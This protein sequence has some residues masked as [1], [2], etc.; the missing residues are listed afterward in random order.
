MNR[1]LIIVVPAVEKGRGGGHLCR[2]V[3]LAS[4][5]RSAGREAFLFLPDQSEKAHA[6]EID[7]LVESM[8]FNP[9]WCITNE[10]IIGSRE[11]IEFV[12]LDRFQTPKEELS[13]WKK[14]APVIG[15]DEGGSS[16]GGFDFLIDILV[17]EKLGFPPA[18]IASPALLNFPPKAPAKKQPPDGKL[19]ILVTFGHEDSAG[20]GLAVTR[21]L[22]DQNGADKMDVT[23]LCGALSKCE[24]ENLP[25]AKIIEAIPSLAEHLGEYDL[26]ITHYGITSYEALYAGAMVLLASPTKYHAKLAKAAGFLKLETKKS[27]LLIP[28]SSFLNRLEKHCEALAV[29]YKL[30][31]GVDLAALC[32]GFSPM[33]N[34]RCPVCG[35]NLCGANTPER[36]VS[37]FSDRTYRRCYACGV[38]YIDRISPPQI[39]YEKE[40]FFES[41]KRQYGKTYLEDFDNIKEAGKRRAKKIKSL[42]PAAQERTLLDIGC[43]Y[44][45]FLA[46]AK[47]EGFNA[48]G[49]DPAEDAVRYVRQQLGIPAVRDFFPSS[50][51]PAPP[52]FDAVTLWFVIEHFTDC[53]AV[54][55]AIRNILKPGGII[56][57][58]TP[59]F[60]GISGRSCLRRF[61]SA[62]PVDHFTVWSPAMCKKALALAG[63]KVKKIVTS[64]CHPERFPLLGRFAKS[65]KSP[66]YWPLL[67]VGKFFKLGDTFE[68]YAEKIRN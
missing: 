10:Q 21:S 24:I 20:L 6:L 61:L 37:R 31:E 4:G 35:A 8:N 60:S 64:G 58:S 33:V 63:F 52:P 3:T 42:L 68:V 67:A 47:E 14:I 48:A 56:A 27:S 1:G 28:N 62:S 25:K 46:A 13:R 12:I 65:K 5:L 51:F 39:E 38:I 55:A 9:E 43:A 22:C 34:R 29:K 15:I 18:N 36:G 41:Y 57:F 59:S 23:I 66:L 19:K 54:L 30:G 53:A 50:Q 44:G 26:V 49:I 45:P 11:Q 17:P 32:G 16:R 7:S 40:Y 2:C